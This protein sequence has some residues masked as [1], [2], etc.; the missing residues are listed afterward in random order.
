MV[1][2]L[3]K[4]RASCPGWSGVPGDVVEV[5]ESEA[6]ALVAGGYADRVRVVDAVAGGPAVET[7]EAGANYE[8]REEGGP[9][10]GMKADDSGEEKKAPA[11]GKKA[12]KG[13]K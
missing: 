6:A 2:V 12:G 7:T 8:V 1:Q 11:A 13:K 9:L 10:M 4:S 5:S 3:L